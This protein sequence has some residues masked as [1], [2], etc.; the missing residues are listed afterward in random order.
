MAFKGI[1][2]LDLGEASSAVVNSGFYQSILSET[3][4]IGDFVALLKKRSHVN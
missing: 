1:A 3:L 4:A 2:E